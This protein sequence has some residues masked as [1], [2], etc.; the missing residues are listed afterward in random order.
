M[1]LNDKQLLFLSQIVRLANWNTPG[2]DRL[3]I[4]HRRD[5]RIQVSWRFRISDSIPPYT[6]SDNEDFMYISES[7]VKKSL[8]CMSESLVNQYNIKL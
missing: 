1:I 5:Q 8:L 6:I 3:R 2:F 4:T 7:D